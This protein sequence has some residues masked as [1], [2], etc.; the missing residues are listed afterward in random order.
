MLKVKL[1]ESNAR[2]KGEARDRLVFQK[3]RKNFTLPLMK[4]MNHK[5]ELIFWK[6]IYKNS[7]LVKNP[8]TW[9]DSPSWH[10]KSSENNLD[11]QHTLRQYWEVDRSRQVVEHPRIQVQCHLGKR[12]D[13][14][15][16]GRP[17][18]VPH[19]VTLLQCLGPGCSAL[20]TR[21]TSRVLS[22]VVA[23]VALPS[24]R[25]RLMS[26]SLVCQLSSSNSICVS[27]LPCMSYCPYCDEANHQSA[28]S[29]RTSRHSL[30]TCYVCTWFYGY[31]S[32]QF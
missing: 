28:K 19:V 29:G 14:H 15:N 23:R 25:V 24:A 32:A 22:S 12:T 4:Y 2:V 17:A 20:V 31:H 16:T 3:L 9:C 13:T 26:A 30:F 18:C 10:Q 1:G 11:R 8:D 6:K 7:K 5:T 21:L 27:V